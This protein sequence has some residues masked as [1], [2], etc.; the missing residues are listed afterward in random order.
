MIQL[1]RTYAKNLLRKLYD[2]KCNAKVTQTI[3][4]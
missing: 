3:A 2:A 1:K 4:K